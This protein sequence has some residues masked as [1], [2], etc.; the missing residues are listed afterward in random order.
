MK[1]KIGE[2]DNMFDVTAIFVMEFGIPNY[3][4]DENS[5]RPLA[6]VGITDV[7]I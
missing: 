6:C 4:E 5:M 2:N 1:I 7:E 3:V